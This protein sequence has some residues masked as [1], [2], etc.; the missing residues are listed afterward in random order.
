M[1]N[2]IVICN[3]EDYTWQIE[4][5]NLILTKKEP[6]IT[7]EKLFQK[8]LRGSTIT[9]CQIDDHNIPEK[10]LKFKKILMH[11]YVDIDI[12]LL[13][14][15]TELNIIREKKH[16]K[17]FEWHEELQIS[18]Q[19]ADARRTL[20][21]IIN[22]TKILNKKLKINLELEDGEKIIAFF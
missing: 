21:E 3:I 11:L 12:E 18:M 16:D 13:L 17:G 1:E 10:Q 14:Q 22:I 9:K 20:K 5:G 19:G 2:Q 6:Y 7:E 15:K 8:N 4:N